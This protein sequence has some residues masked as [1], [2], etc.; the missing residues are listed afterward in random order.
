MSMGNKAVAGHSTRETV[1]NESDI[2]Y[3]LPEMLDSN[4]SDFLD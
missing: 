1:D 4:V 3:R 2:G